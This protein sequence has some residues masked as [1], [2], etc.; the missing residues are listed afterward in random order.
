MQSKVDPNIQGRV[1]G[2]RM[3][4][5]TFAFAAAY[6][7]SGIL[8]DRLFEPL[9]AQTGFLAASAGSLLGTGPGRGMGLMFV[10]MGLLAVL[11]ALGGFAHP[12]LRNVEHELPDTVAG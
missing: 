3:F 6:L 1:I 11:T 4:M 10:L 2:L 8:A 12:R 9:M 7:L 5:N